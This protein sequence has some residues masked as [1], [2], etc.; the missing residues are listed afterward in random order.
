MRYE[1]TATMD[2]DQ[3]AR[4]ISVDRT[5]FQSEEMLERHISVKVS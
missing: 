3:R 1:P 2:V 5:E 4:K